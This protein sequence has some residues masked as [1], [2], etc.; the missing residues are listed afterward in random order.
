MTSLSLFTFMHWRRKWQPTPLFMPGESHGK[1]SLVGYSSQSRK[2]LD[3]TEQLHFTSLMSVTTSSTVNICQ[4]QGLWSNIKVGSFVTVIFLGP[5]PNSYLQIL[6]ELPPLWDTMC[7]LLPIVLTLLCYNL[8][9][10]QVVMLHQNPPS[11]T[12]PGTSESC[13]LSNAEMTWPPSHVFAI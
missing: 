7:L 5:L 13:S 11:L 6:T 3:K 4:L 12:V 8:G 10:P 2:E 9:S 1:R